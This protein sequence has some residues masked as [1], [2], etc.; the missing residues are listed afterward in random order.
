LFVFGLVMLVRQMGM[1]VKTVTA[2]TLGHSVTLTLAVLGFVAYPTGLI[3]S[4]IALSVFLLAVELSRDE[5]ANPT[6]I[7]RFPWLMAGSFG[8]LHGLG[9]A[10]ALE[11]AGLPAGEIPLALLAFNLGIELGQLAFVAVVVAARAAARSLVERLP[12]WTRL[13][14]LYV[15]GS[16]AA[17]WFFER[18]RA[19][20]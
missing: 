11:E 2:F 8:L 16:L 19:L 13:A 7:R 12:Q 6:F 1:L 4:S 17:F 18:T 20:F 10:G 3:E 14:P 9:F 15:M 5:T